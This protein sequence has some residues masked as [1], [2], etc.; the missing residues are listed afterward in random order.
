M[1]SNDFRNV[2]NNRLMTLFVWINLLEKDL[3]QFFRSHYSRAELMNINTY[4]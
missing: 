1:Y 3:D 2:T 4:E